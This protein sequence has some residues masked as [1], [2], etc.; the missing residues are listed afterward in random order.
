MRKEKVLVGK[1]IRSHGSGSWQFPGGHLEFGEGVEACAK[2]EVYE[3]TGLQIQNIR[4]GPYTND[5]FQQEGKHYIT[6]F[7]LADCTS[8]EPVLKEP[9]K[10]EKWDWRRWGDLPR[11]FFLPMANLLEQ[12]FD[13]W[14]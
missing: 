10:C 1:R 11:P 13:P 12:G 14:S 8:G 5:I 4:P 7:V 3:E 2:R 6:L 9:E